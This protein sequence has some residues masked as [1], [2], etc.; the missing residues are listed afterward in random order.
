[1]ECDAGGDGYVGG[2]GML[3]GGAAGDG[4]ERR[5]EMVGAEGV[6][7]AEGGGGGEDSGGG[8]N[9]AVEDGEEVAGGGE[10]GRRGGGT[11]E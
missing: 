9:G 10:H 5:A 11:G 6:A 8:A 7:T 2:N 4:A 3:L 1:M